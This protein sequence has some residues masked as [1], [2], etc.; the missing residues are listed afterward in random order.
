MRKKKVFLKNIPK[1]PNFFP[2]EI[3]W[4]N[5]NLS[6]LHILHG[7]F[8][9]LEANYI[10]DNESLF[11]FNYIH[12]FL[13]FNLKAPNWNSFFISGLSFKRG[14]K[15]IGLITSLPKLIVLKNYIISCSEINYLCLQKKIRSRKLVSVL[16][17]EITRKLNSIGIVQAVYTT[18][19]TFL[20]SFITCR[21][22]HYPLNIVKLFDLG[23]LKS[24]CLLNL[25]RI[26]PNKIQLF[27]KKKK[28]KFSF[29]FGIRKKLINLNTYICFRKEDFLHWFR[30]VQGVFYVIFFSFRKK[31]NLKISSFYSLPNKI[32]EKKKK[33]FLF[34][35]YWYFGFFKISLKICFKK[36]L[37]IIYDLGFDMFNTLGSFSKKKFFKTLGFKK[38]NG[39]LQFHIFNWRKKKISDQENG[40]VFF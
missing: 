40:L 35:S 25:K 15:L 22:Y 21:Y 34:I 32:I 8:S 10:E 23:F 3:C 5:L 38:G 4:K 16:I 29:Y 36:L 13:N 14:N 26:F 27:K 37:Q 17:K 11:R 18:S 20:E 19:V 28:K 7:V 24:P 9:F 6:N 12:E 31:K 33:L 39:L 1:N 30:T 2:F